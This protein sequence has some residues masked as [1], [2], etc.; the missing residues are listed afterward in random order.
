MTPSIEMLIVLCGSPLI[1]EARP[2]PGVSTPGRN[3][4]KFSALRVT[5][6][7]FE[8]TSMLTVELTVVAVVC[9]E[10]RLRLDVDGLGELRRP[11][12]SRAGRRR[13]ASSRTSVW[14]NVL[15]PDSDTVTV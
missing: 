9:D 6:G 2:V 12:A 4:T 3:V 7:R 14:T 10:L 11:R 13:P 15:N 8:I 1:V 5:T